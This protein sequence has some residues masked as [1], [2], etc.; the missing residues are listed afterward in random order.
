MTM[1][2]AQ[3]IDELLALSER[4]L[5]RLDASVSRLERRMDRHDEALEE[6]EEKLARLEAG[7]SRHERRMDRHDQ[8]LEELEER[9]SD[10][11]E[12]FGEIKLERLDENRLDRVLADAKQRIE[13]IEA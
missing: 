12:I 9:T 1:T 8:A 4:K 13:R 6:L 2:S 11:E 7:V 5:A 3:R 10:C